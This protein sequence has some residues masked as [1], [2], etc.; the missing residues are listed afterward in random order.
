MFAT[1]LIGLRE[2]LEAALVVGMLVAY[3]SRLG[4]RDVLP[5]LWAGV[6]V[7]VALAVTVIQKGFESLEKDLATHGSLTAGFVPYTDLT[8]ADKRALVDDINTLAEPLSRLTG[9][10][11]N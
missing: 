1:F 8:E 9:T 6:G 5:R 10:I 4:R 7:P 3:V 11:L 2:G